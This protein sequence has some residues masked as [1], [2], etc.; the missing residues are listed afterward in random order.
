MRKSFAAVFACT[1]SLVFGQTVDSFSDDQWDSLATLRVQPQSDTLSLSEAILI[2]LERNYDI[3]IEE[4]NVQVATTNNNWGQAGR[5]PTISLNLDQRN[6][7]T[8]NIK[9]VNPFQIPGQTTVNSLVPNVNLNWVLFDGFSIFLTKRRLEQLQAETAGNAS[10]VIANTIQ[11]TILAYYIGV[12]EKE[13][14]SEFGKQLKLSRDRYEYTRS[15]AELGSAVSSDVLLEEGNF[16]TDSINY[17]N[18]QLA[19]RNAVRNLNVLLAEP[20]VDKSYV[21]TD[22]LNLTPQLYDYETLRTRMFTENVDVRRQFITQEILKTD[23]KVAR[24]DRWPRLAFNAGFSETR[25]SVFFDPGFTSPDGSAINGGNSIT[26]NYFANFTLSFTLFNGGQINRAIKNA[27]VQADIGSLRVDRLK[28]S[29]D[30]DLSEAYDRYQART[31]LF[32][33]TQRQKEAA[34]TNLQISQQKFRNGSINSFDF[35]VVQNNYLSSA[36]L[37]LQAAYNLIDSKIDL[38]RI[39]GGLIRDYGN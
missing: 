34:L 29:L 31:Q 21:L 6:A 25:S 26:D 2:A 32:M 18:Q 14:L 35:R 17:I 24:S 16:L 8:D 27:A 38:M 19:L 7:L 15:K 23:I 12:L 36:I 5:W 28:N 33:I 9:L 4:G 13:R 22:S 3:R 30:R 11:S 10:I 37:N 39:T 20:E 1:A